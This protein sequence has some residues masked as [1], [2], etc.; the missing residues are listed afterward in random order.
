MTI[1]TFTFF[2]DPESSKSAQVFKGQFKD[3]SE[4][5]EQP[6]AYTVHI[7]GRNLHLRES[8]SYGGYALL[9]GTLKGFSK[10]R[11]QIEGFRKTAHVKKDGIYTG[12][13]AFVDFEGKQYTWNVSFFRGSWKLPDTTGTTIASFDRQTWKTDIEGHLTIHTDI[14]ESLLALIILTSK[15]VHNRVKSKEKSGSR[16]VGASM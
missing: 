16:G 10:S 14:P 12:A 6:R 1:T 4:L 15:L 8:T 2:D 5:R 11:A 3:R 13:W 9:F 7:D